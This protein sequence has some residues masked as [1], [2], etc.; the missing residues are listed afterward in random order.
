MQVFSKTRF[1]SVIVLFGTGI[2]L[3]LPIFG[4]KNPFQL[5]SPEPPE[6]SL[7]RRVPAT[8]P[9]MVLTNLK[10]AIAEKNLENYMKC[11]VDSLPGG[12]KFHFVA[13]PSS[14][15]QNPGLFENWTIESEKRYANYL[16]SQIPKDSTAHLDFKVTKEY[17]IQ[18]TTFFQGDYTLLLRHK[19]D[20]KQYP[21]KAVG[22]AEFRLCQVQGEWFIFYWEDRGD[23]QEPSW[24]DVKAAFGK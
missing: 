15:I 13:D 5:R 11:L 21:R 14:Q 18:D 12:K 23:G 17:I 19:L 1:F 10:N 16:F 4:C 24:S 7:T 9:D 2:F 20:E 3:V 22:R 6:K 8:Q